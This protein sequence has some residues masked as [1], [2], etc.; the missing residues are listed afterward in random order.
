V[1]SLK[2]SRNFEVDLHRLKVHL[3]MVQE[4]V[5]RMAGETLESQKTERH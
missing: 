4:D 5:A 3:R 2:V 1:R